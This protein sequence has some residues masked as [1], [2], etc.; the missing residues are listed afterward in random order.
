MLTYNPFRTS[1]KTEEIKAYCNYEV[2]LELVTTMYNLFLLLLTY[3]I[4][5]QKINKIQ[6]PHIFSFNL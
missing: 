1:V 2:I 4:H 5:K 3:K 6:G